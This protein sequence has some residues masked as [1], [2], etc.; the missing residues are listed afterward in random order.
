MNTPHKYAEA[1]K[2]WADGR[3]IQYQYIEKLK[4]DDSWL[5]LP[6]KD[7]PDFSPNIYKFRIKPETLRYRVAL[8]HGHP[9]AEVPYYLRIATDE[10]EQKQ[11]LMLSGIFVKWL[12][13]WVTIEL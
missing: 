1:I 12:T 7:N 10:K 2:A 9:D 3:E 13:E 11:I 5:T 4:G 8:L 6:P